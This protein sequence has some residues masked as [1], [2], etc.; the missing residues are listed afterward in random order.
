M[1]GG[2][3]PSGLPVQPVSTLYKRC[4]LICHI[5]TRTILPTKFIATASSTTTAVHLMR[6]VMTTSRPQIAPNSEP[7]ALTFAVQGRA[8]FNQRSSGRWEPEAI[9][10]GMSSSYMVDIPRW[11]VRRFEFAFMGRFV[12]PVGATFQYAHT[13]DV[14][15]RCLVT[16]IKFMFTARALQAYALYIASHSFSDLYEKGPEK[17]ILHSS[18]LLLCAF[19]RSL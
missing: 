13:M 6:A 14:S 8:V 12:S 15:T 19:L 3:F 11:Y 10:A 1:Q 7:F 16:C 4:G 5:Y 18:I 2:Y 17:Y 9:T